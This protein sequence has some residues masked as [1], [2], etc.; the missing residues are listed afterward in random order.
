MSQLLPHHQA[1]I[2]ASAISPEIAV[3]RGYRSIT[4]PDELRSLGFANYQC[5]T[6]SLLVPIRDAFGQNGYYQ[7]RPDAPRLNAAGHVVKYE[8]IAGSRPV[9][10]VSSRVRPLLD[11]PAIPLWITEGAR[12]VDAA[13]S[14]GLC[15]IGVNGVWAWRGTNAKRGKTALSDWEVIALNGRTVYL[16]FDSDVTTKAS[17]QGALVRLAAFLSARSATVQFVILPEGV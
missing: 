15:C 4:D 11:D 1:L 10:D 3:E 13:V 6:P 7:S 8:S 9:L 16:A 5:L 14:H 2:D 12:K 17:V